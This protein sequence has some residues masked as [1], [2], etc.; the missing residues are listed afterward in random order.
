M[1]GFVTRVEILRRAVLNPVLL[2]VVCVIGDDAESAFRSGVHA[3]KHVG[4]F[5]AVVCRP[6][7]PL[8]TT[9]MRSTFAV[10]PLIYRGHRYGVVA[11]RGGL[12]GA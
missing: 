4:N 3:L 11:G 10:M 12:E 6:T 8:L 1:F 7:L 2:W 5:T 9:A